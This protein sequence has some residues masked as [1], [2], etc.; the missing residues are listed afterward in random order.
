LQR[1]N[2]SIIIYLRVK[3]SEWARK[4]GIS[5]LTAWRWFRTGKLPV[6]ARQLP[7]GTILVEEPSPGGRTVLYARVS[8]PDQ[9]ADLERQVERLKAFAQAQGWRD[10]EVVA[11]V[12]T[13]SR[14]RKGLL[15]VLA[16][17]GVSLVVVERRFHLG[18]FGFP[19]VEAA[20]RAS[21]R[22]VLALEDEAALPSRPPSRRKRERQKASR[23]NR[24]PTRRRSGV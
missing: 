6:P 1:V 19:L 13:A 5:Y 11:E 12:G 20:L 21:G 10:F 4:H 15:R 22:R 17:P 9:K 7:S 3:L 16:D 2:A 18:Q 24:E 8:S 14:R 23:G